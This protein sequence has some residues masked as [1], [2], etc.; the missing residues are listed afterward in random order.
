MSSGEDLVVVRSRIA[1]ALEIQENDTVDFRFDVVGETFPLKVQIRD[2]ICSDVLIHDLYGLGIS[3][4]IL[5]DDEGET[6][7]FHSGQKV[8]LPRQY[9]WAGV[10]EIIQKKGSACIFFAGVHINNSLLIGSAGYGFRILEGS[11]GEG[12]EFVEGY[13]YAGIGRSGDEMQYEGLMEGLTWAIRLDA[14]K[15]TICGDSERMIN[16][17]NQECPV[18]DSLACLHQKVQEMLQTNCDLEVTFKHIQQED[19][20]ISDNLANR[21]IATKKNAVLVDWPNVNKFMSY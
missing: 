21:A 9:M 15:L 8:W 17:F 12:D 1:K 4:R 6:I 19:N 20:V 11:E 3:R 5:V 14:A 16:S 2:N 10:R 18:I 13:G 7:L